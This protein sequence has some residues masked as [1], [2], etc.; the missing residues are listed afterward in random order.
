MAAWHAGAGC[1]YR[2]GSRHLTSLTRCPGVLK[3]AQVH[4]FLLGYLSGQLGLV[5]V[6]LVDVTLWS[7]PAVGGER[8]EGD[9]QGPQCVHALNAEGKKIPPS[10]PPPSFF[11]LSPREN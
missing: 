3:T 7:Q 1:P 5:M 11:L 6:P 10:C 9:P 4:S 8:E 2:L